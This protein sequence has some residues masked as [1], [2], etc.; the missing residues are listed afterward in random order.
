MKLRPSRI[1]DALTGAAVE[2]AANAAAAARSALELATRAT[3]A[4][5]TCSIKGAALV[6]GVSELTIYA[7]RQ[8]PDFPKARALADGGR[9]GR[10]NRWIVSELLAWLARQPVAELDCEPKQLRGRKY[11][12]GRPAPQRGVV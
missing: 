12:D 9:L 7:L 3:L 8:R 5:F 6:I 4:S 2:R 11:R 10:L 1:D